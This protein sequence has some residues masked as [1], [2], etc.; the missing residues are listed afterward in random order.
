MHNG[1]LTAASSVSVPSS[2]SVNAVTVGEKR[3]RRMK[4]LGRS[5]LRRFCSVCESCVDFDAACFSTANTT[6]CIARDVQRI[7]EQTKE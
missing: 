6:W 4:R 5:A 2:F 7:D 3:M 1:P